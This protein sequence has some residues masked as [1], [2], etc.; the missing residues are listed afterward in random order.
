MMSLLKASTMY[1][2]NNKYYGTLISPPYHM[3]FV[4]KDPVLPPYLAIPRPLTY[5][6]TAA[7]IAAEKSI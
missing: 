3:F 7:V 5:T 4:R 2:V 1:H 6:S